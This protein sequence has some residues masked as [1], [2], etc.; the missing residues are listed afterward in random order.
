MTLPILI[1]FAGPDGVGKSTTCESFAALS[2]RQVA[3]RSFAGPLYAAASAIL[4]VPVEE[5]KRR[6]KEVLTEETAPLPFLV[7]KTFR[8][9]LR[10]L[11][12]DACR[13]HIHRSIW[14]QAARRAAY[15]GAAVM[16]ATVVVFDD[17]RFP[18]EAGICDLVFE[19]GRTGAAYSREHASDVGLPAEVPRDNLSLD[20]PIEDVVRTIVDLM[21]VAPHKHKEAWMDLIQTGAPIAA[22]L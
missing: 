15:N 11:G 10:V 12:T 6:K 16:G 21:G 5:L 8:W 20:Q 9:F 19:L 13:D 17:L 2:G 4:G 22:E 18:N 1:G 7:G 3:I 14:T